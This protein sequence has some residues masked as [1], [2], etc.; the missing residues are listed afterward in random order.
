VWVA[1]ANGRDARRLAAGSDPSLSPNGRL[2]AFVTPDGAGTEFRSTTPGGYSGGTSVSGAT[3]QVLAWSHDSRFVAIAYTGTRTSNSG[4]AVVGVGTTGSLS[5]TPV[6]QGFVSGASF[7]PRGDRLV[8]AI[9]SSQ[10]LGARVDLFTANAD[11]T[12]ARR[13]TD[14]GRSL[15]PVWGRRGIAF[16]RERLRGRSEAPEYQVW[17]MRGGRTTQLT[18]LRVPP[19]LDGLVPLQFDAA[20]N[21]LLAEYSG[22]DTSY[23][24]T[25]QLKP[26]RVRAVRVRGR[27]VQ[28]AAISRSGRELL[29]DEGAFENPPSRGRVESVPFGG[30]PATVLTSG[31][32][33]SW[34][35]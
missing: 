22:E 25:I 24:Y 7:A 33:P 23:A 4:L 32:Q 5:I 26:R 35:R 28:P 27:L 29:V 6:A 31:A 18:H 16:D 17:L 15:Y 3:E 14:D 19:L 34:N 12:H 1:K 9:S 30:G 10:R 11:R 8:Y 13:L 21:R 2:V 20:G